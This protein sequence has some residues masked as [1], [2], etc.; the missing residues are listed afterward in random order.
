MRDLVNQNCNLG[1]GPSPSPMSGIGM[2]GHHVVAGRR[3]RIPHLR[4]RLDSLGLKLVELVDI[5]QDFV[6]VGAQRLFLFRSQAE[7]CE[8]GDVP[9]L[10]GSYSAMCHR[11]EIVTS[12]P[13][14]V[15]GE[16]LQRAGALPSLIPLR[17]LAGRGVTRIR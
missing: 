3:A 15:R 14:R 4:S 6:H 12:S 17:W 1:R 11:M 13:F 5:A 16:R 8:Q 7:P 10:L 2:V 9:H